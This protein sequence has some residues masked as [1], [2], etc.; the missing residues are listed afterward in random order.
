MDDTQQLMRILKDMCIII[1]GFIKHAKRFKELSHH[2]SK[3]YPSMSTK[4]ISDR[5]E[6]MLIIMCEYNV[7]E[8]KVSPELESILKNADGVNI[9][10]Y[11][12]GIWNLHKD[13]IDDQLLKNNKQICDAFGDKL[14]AEPINN[15]TTRTSARPLSKKISVQ[16][17]QKGTKD[18]GPAKPAPFNAR[19]KRPGP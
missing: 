7:V 4:D 10:I 16:T 5:V 8:Y 15:N 2:F 13:W 14:S 18:N 17:Y 9:N 11:H 6:S 1:D 19:N 12:H 3:S